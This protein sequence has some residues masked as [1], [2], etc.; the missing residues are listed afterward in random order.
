MNNWNNKNRVLVIPD[1]HHKVEIADSII[2]NQPHDVRVFLGD[3][4]DDFHD[5]SYEARNT[6]RWVKNQLSQPNVIALF[7]NHDL[8]YAPFN[9]SY[10][11]SCSGYTR[12]KD[13]S[14]KDILMPEDW[15]KFKF[16]TIQ[17]GWLLSHAG[18]SKY[19][20]TG[21]K[22]TIKTYLEK[23]EVVARKFLSENKVHWFYVIGR[24]RF[25]LSPCGGLTWCDI[26]EFKP[27]RYV[28]Q[29][30]GH[31]PLHVPRFINDT[32]VCLDTHLHYYGVIENGELTIHPLDFK[33][34]F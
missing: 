17:D 19:F 6:A 24:R 9:S 18:V 1:V 11:K 22:N 33:K 31:T 25:G 32:N 34:V 3:F 10:A 30:F 29:I 14:I 27:I 28:K 23:E 4:F 20:Y 26:H 12:D 7:G 15:A 16:W 8:A 13:E 2:E 21:K 5:S